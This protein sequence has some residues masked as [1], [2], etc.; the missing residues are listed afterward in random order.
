MEPHQTP[1]TE[2]NNQDSSFSQIS[3]PTAPTS[4]SSFNSPNGHFVQSQPG[5]DSS[6]GYPLQTPPNPK[7]YRTIMW[8]I[9]GGVLLVIILIIVVLL[10]KNHNSNKNTNSTATKSQ[11]QLQPT[12]PGDG[13]CSAGANYGQVAISGGATCTT[14][15]AVAQAANG[16]NFTSNGYSCSATTEAK[17]SNTQW[18]SYWS[19]TFY[20]Y[21]CSNAQKDQIAFNWQSSTASQQENTSQ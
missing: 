20:A 5:Q 14:A 10:I 7:S 4:T 16:S 17:G 11:S 6:N 8:A 1:S 9:T 18:S 2:T 3:N 15:E 19:G 13:E 12:Q 21:T